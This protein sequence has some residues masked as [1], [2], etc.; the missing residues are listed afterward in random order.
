M[1]QIAEY[2]AIE[3]MRLD[4]GMYT[5]EQLKP[6]HKNHIEKSTVEL[7]VDN[8]LDA[9]FRVFYFFLMFKQLRLILHSIR[10]RIY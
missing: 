4:V 1:S 9:T 2:F 5:T 10:Q 8:S 6:H 3:W 7:K